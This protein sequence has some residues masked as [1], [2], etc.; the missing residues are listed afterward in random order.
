LERIGEAAYRLDLPTNSRVHPVLHVSQ[1]K[2][3]VAKDCPVSEDLTSVCTDPASADQPE[4]VLDRR[5]IQRGGNTIKQVL[6]KWGALP[7]TMATCEDDDKSF[8]NLKASPT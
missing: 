5:M 2:Q 4:Q 8:D 3:H 7:L 6:M 1:L